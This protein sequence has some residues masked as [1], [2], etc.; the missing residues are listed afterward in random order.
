M[1]QKKNSMTKKQ[2]LR[3]IMAFF[4]VCKLSF[5]LTL[6]I[7][8]SISY[9]FEPKGWAKYKTS[10]LARAQEKG[11]RDKHECEKEWR[12]WNLHIQLEK[13]VK[14]SW[15]SRDFFVE[16]KKIISILLNQQ[17]SS[18]NMAKEKTIH[19]FSRK[20]QEVFFTTN[21][22]LMTAEWAILEE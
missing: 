18:I 6:S 9:Y 15:D 2:K 17:Y 11:S 16:Q 10:I 12:A 1:N 13:N 3:L 22:Q 7:S 14:W 20:I 4:F 8:V 5:S 21:K 19:F